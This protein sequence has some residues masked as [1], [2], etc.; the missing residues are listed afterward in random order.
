MP[1]EVKERPVTYYEDLARF[2]R[3]EARL[4]DHAVRAKH[5]LADLERRKEYPDLVL[6]ATG[7]FA[8]AQGV[9]DPQNAFMSHYF[10]STAAGVAA[11]LRM[12]LD[13]G[14]KHRARAAH[15]APRRPRSTTGASR[16]WAASCSRCARPTTR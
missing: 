1:P 9:D 10:N 16:R 5:A 8:Y 13:L 7:A 4:L 2:N 14:P 15:S 12:Q 6:I 3:P 11:A